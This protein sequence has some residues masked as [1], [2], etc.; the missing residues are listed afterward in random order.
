MTKN[1]NTEGAANSFTDYNAPNDTQT[2]RQQPERSP[3]NSQTTP[4]R[5]PNDPRTT[6]RMTPTP[7]PPRPHPAPQNNEKTRSVSQTIEEVSAIISSTF[8][9]KSELFSRGKG[10]FKVWSFRTKHRTKQDAAIGTEQNTERRTPRTPNA[11]RR[12]PNSVH[13]TK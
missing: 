12:T 6:P 10:L 7:T 2:I 11:E 5:P 9:S 8:S 4:E 1:C 3:N 13:R